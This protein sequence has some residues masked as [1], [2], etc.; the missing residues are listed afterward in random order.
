MLSM[1]EYG[2]HEVMDAAGVKN[3]QIPPNHDVFQY[4]E[5]RLNC[6]IWKSKHC[7]CG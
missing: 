2:I 3:I 4:G 5:S 1:S 6:E 7:F